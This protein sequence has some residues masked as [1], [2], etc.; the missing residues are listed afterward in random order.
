MSHQLS[1]WRAAQLL[2]VTRGILQQQVRNGDLML[3]DGFLSSDELLRLYPHIQFEESGMLERVVQIRTESF[4]KR[5]RER[6]LPS[7][8]VLAQRVF[9]Q[10]QELADVR[11]LLKQYHDLVISLQKSAK[12][13]VI[14]NPSNH[15]IT[16][17]ENQISQGLGKVLATEPVD[18]LE[19]MDDMLKVMTSQVTVRPSGHEFVVEGH[20]TLLQSGLQAGLKLIYGCGNGSCGMCKVR[21]ISGEVVKTQHYDYQLSETEKVQGYTLMCCHTPSSSELSIEVLEVEGPQ[22]IPEQLIIAQVRKIQEIA[23]NITLLHLQTP[24]THRFRFLAGQATTLSLEIPSIGSVKA[25]YP[26]GSCPCDDRNLFFYI[27]KSETDAFAKHLFAGDITAGSQIS[28]LGPTGD[29]VLAEGN[30]P[31]VFATCDNGFA[32][33]K[34]LIEYAFSLDAA[35]SLSLFWLATEVGGHYLNN[36]CRAWSEALDQFEYDLI[37]NADTVEGARQIAQTMRQDLFDINCDFYITGPEE[38]INALT[39]ELRDAG[40]PALQI[41]SLIV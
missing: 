13:M 3:N 36:Q 19:I 26:M 40:V 24:R 4:G 34:S 18:V 30:R 37:T 6:M 9:A 22:D 39:Q 21:V 29:F 27:E 32:P 20:S 41:Y 35:P 14:Q 7:Q 23:P 10:S 31:L 33:I 15:E 11:K 38:F 8:E 2:G 25:S 17:L 1:V 12:S 16:N 28:V 5:I